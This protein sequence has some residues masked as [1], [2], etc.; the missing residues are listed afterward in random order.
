MPDRIER[1]SLVD[2][3]RDLGAVDFHRRQGRRVTEG[4]VGPAVVVEAE[5]GLQV[6]EGVD[7]GAVALQVSGA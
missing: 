5:E 2:G 6:R 1:G 3:Q 4:A 7:L